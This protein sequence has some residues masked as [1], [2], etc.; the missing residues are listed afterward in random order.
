V[1]A[2]VLPDELVL[3]D[4]QLDDSIPCEVRKI[5]DEGPECT[6][7][8]GFLVRW[9]DVCANGMRLPGDP[10]TFLCGAHAARLSR[11]E[12]TRGMCCGGCDRPLGRDVFHI[13]ASISPVPR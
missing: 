1:T 9:R 4:A 7:E 12:Y 10:V 13:V 8:A 3:L 5:V 6:C 11:G 2:P